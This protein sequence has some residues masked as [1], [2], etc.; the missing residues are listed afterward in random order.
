MLKQELRRE[1]RLRKRQYTKEQLSVMSATIIRKLVADSHFVS[2]QTILMYFSLDDEVYTH[3]L[4]NDM[5]GEKKILLPSVIDEEN[6][7]LHVYRQADDLREGAF[8]I[9]EP[10][11]ELF[12][13]YEDIDV[14]VIPG[15]AFDRQGNRMGRGKGYY[16]RILAKIPNAYK[17]GICFEFQLFDEIPT[18]GYDITMDRVIS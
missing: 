11:G 2:A 1:V 3:Q 5:A 15:M 14:A 12:T 7:A 4:V 8:H 17:I 16:D 10:T 6:L 9:M 13:R 18:D